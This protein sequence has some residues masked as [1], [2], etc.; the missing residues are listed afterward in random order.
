MSPCHWI[1]M[2]NGTVAHVRMPKP[3]AKHCYK[4][5]RPANKLCDGIVSPPEQITHKRTC[6][7]P[8]CD[9]CAHHVPGKDLDYCG[10]CADKLGVSLIL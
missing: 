6:D 2:P 10:E 9:V 3:R 5:G 7:K 4:C 1:R 8:L